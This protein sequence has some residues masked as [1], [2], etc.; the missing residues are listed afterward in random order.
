MLFESMP[1]N[2]IVY[3]HNDMV[4]E[5]KEKDSVRKDVL[6]RAYRLYDHVAIVSEEQRKP[7]ETVASYAKGDGL[8]DKANIV[9]AKNVIN[10]ERVLELK[11]EPFV[12]DELTELN[13]GEEQLEELLSSKKKKFVTIG[14]FSKEKGHLRL[15]KAFEKVYQEN[16]DTCLIILGGYGD[17]YEKTLER[18]AQSVAK[19]AIVIIKYLSNPYALLARCDYFVLS[20]FYEGLPVVLTEADL[21]GLPCFSTDIPGPRKF[22]Q[23]YGGMLVENDEAGI[24]DGMKKCLSGQVPAKLTLD[25]EQYNREAVELFESMLQ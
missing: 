20:S 23:Q 14:R 10:Y 21:V 7:T 8:R 9:L 2:K 17:M 24:V 4:Q 12:V 3:V 15:I 25:Y 22:M 19:D 5:L 1:C 16:S 13:V 6:S 11:E 18:A